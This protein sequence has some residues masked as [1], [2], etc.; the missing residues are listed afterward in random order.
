MIHC[1]N[2]HLGREETLKNDVAEIRPTSEKLL[3][4]AITIEPLKKQESIEEHNPL[5]VLC[6]DEEFLVPNDLDEEIENY[7]PAYANDKVD[8][9]PSKV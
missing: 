9:T 4:N 5:E 2:S 1:N 6:I 3:N 8:K 7:L